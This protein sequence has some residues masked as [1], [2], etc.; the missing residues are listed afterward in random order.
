MAF[1]SI[2]PLGQPFPAFGEAPAL[3]TYAQYVTALN[4]PL[5][6]RFR[7]TSGNPVNSGSL[8]L[9]ITNTVTTQGITGKLGPNEAYDFAGEAANGGIVSITNNATLKAMTTQRWAF[10]VHPDTLG[11]LNAAFL[12]VWGAFA[13]TDHCPLRFLSTNR[14]ESLI[15]TNG[16]NAD[17]VTN[18]NQI[19]D[20][21]GV[22]CWFFMDYDDANTLGNGRKIRLFKGLNRTVTQLT[23]A[24]DIAAIGAVDQPASALG[25]GN[26]STRNITMDGQLD[27]VI[28]QPSL[29]TSLEMTRLVNLAG[30]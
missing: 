23:L 19:S 15:N 20:C 25:I 2:R 24:T 3:Q 13:V 26:I 11:A 8:A 14:L 12:A 27:E 22:W 5:W 29:W 4:P 17:A 18:N 1:R 28:V 16:T 10:L 6:L 30:V 21:I 9:T 7:E